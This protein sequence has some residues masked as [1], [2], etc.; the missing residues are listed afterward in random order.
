MSPHKYQYVPDSL[1]N[2]NPFRSQRYEHLAIPSFMEARND[3]PVPVL[4]EYPLWQEMYWRA[5]ELA[6]SHLRRPMP[7][8]GFVA[9]F[10]EPAFNEH[11]FMWNCAFMMQ[12]GLYG[13]HLFNFMG[14]LD[15]FYA[16]QHDDGFICREIDVQSGQDFFYPFD[17]NGTGP[18]ILAWAEWRYFRMTGDDGRLA[19]VFPPLLAYH[20]WCRRHRTWPSGLYWATGLSSGMDNQPRVPDSRDHHQHWTWV[21]AT[22]Q[23]ALNCRVLGLM[24]TQL[25]E[26]DLSLVLNEERN[27]LVQG[28][29]AQMW[30]SEAGF[31]QDVDGKGR[32]SRVKSIGAYWSLL[33]KG[34]VSEDRLINFV[35]PLRENWAFKLDHCI[36]SQSADSEGYNQAGNNWRGGVWSNTNFMVLKGLR[37]IGQ[38]ALA[39]EIAVNHLTNVAE[40]YQHTDTFWEYYMPESAEPGEKAKPDFVGITGLTPIAILL[41]DIIGISADWPLRR[42]VWDRRLDIMSEYGV[43]NYP[44]GSE[45]SMDLLGT[46]EK[47]IVTTDVPFTL[48]IHLNHEHV[49]AAVSTGTTEID[50]S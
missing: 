47:V 37:N 34:I 1:V 35:Q 22:M 13:R 20:N 16:K 2:Q 3:L 14:T 48:T 50:L 19:Q 33:D 30:N 40:V 8:S 27:K 44:L 18:N 41:E 11:L 29:N 49:Q 31:Y 32:F 21:D 6:W 45:G 43:R 26:N 7:E 24:A 39:H 46:P 23:A 25:G 9:N 12:F 4:S 17:P 10:I 28:I 42:V 5:W 15:N 38:Q 36:P